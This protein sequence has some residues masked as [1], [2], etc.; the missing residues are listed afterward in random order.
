MGLHCIATDA[1]TVGTDLAACQ[2]V[3]VCPQIWFPDLI[4][5]RNV[6][7]WKELQIWFPGETLNL[8]GTWKNDLRLTNSM[9]VTVGFVSRC[10]QVKFKNH[11]LAVWFSACLWTMIWTQEFNMKFS[12]RE[13]QSPKNDKLWWSLFQVQVWVIIPRLATV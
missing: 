7:T 11:A 4:P 8:E 13:F 10:Q 1:V 3:S 2:R 9:A 6:K 5:M 12:G